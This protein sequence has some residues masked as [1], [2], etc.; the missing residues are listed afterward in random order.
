MRTCSPLPVLAADPP[1]AQSQMQTPLSSS[2][3][4]LRQKSLSAPASPALRATS[5]SMQAP[6]PLTRQHRLPTPL[7]LM[8]AIARHAQQQQQSAC[9]CSSCSRHHESDGD[10]ADIKDNSAKPVVQITS[11]DDGDDPPHS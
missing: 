11:A 4:L 3:S 8:F 10:E 5:D 6:L 9:A 2:S 7:L 1:S